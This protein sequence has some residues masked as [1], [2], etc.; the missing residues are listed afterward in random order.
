MDPIKIIPD[1]KG[2][3]QGA[4]IHEPF[5]DRA[6][7]SRFEKKADEKLDI[8]LKF[9]DFRWGLEF[10]TE[11]A[12]IMSERGGALFIKLET[13]DRFTLDD[14][15]NGK[16]DKLLETFG[17]G[18][19]N[20]GKPV[21]VSIN[22]EMN[23]TWYKWCCD[24][25]KYK[26]TY[27]YIKEKIESEGAKNITWVWN[28]NIDY[29]FAEYYPGD[30]H[31]DWVA[32]DGYNTVDYGNAWRSFESLFRMN[33]DRLAAFKKPIMIGEF[34]CD[35][36]DDNDRKVRKPKFLTEAINNMAKDGRIKAFVYFDWNK[37]E[38]GQ[39]KAWAIDTPESQKAYREAL[40]KHEA[41][42]RGGILTAPSMPAPDQ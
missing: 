37:N 27:I 22:H 39:D 29:S 35:S 24:P 30:K 16:A 42:F 15:L 20:F 3:Y 21:F 36:N 5:F 6:D 32:I 19:A 26:A 10:P 4:F 41:M 2:I 7:V 11:M 18:A 23:A 13:G 33:L 38:G 31:V 25:D 28:P 1:A 14:I 34:G 40:N 9:M 17:S 12:G 8:A